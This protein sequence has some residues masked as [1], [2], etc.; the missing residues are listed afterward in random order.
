[1]TLEE[2]AKEPTTEEVARCTELLAGAISGAM[3]NVR[4]VA[5]VPDNPR[6]DDPAKCRCG[7]TAAE[8]YCY[9]DC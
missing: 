9:C 5:W 7:A 1:M 8:P 2:Q 3:L 6:P 4:V